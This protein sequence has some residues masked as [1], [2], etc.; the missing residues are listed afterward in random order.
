MNAD[1]TAYIGATG[2]VLSS[3]LFTYCE[4][5]VINYSDHSENATNSKDNISNTYTGSTK[6]G[7]SI[8]SKIYINNKC[9]NIYSSLIKNGVLKFYFDRNPN[10]RK[11]FDMGRTRIVAEALFKA[12]KS[13]NK[14]YKKQYLKG[15]TIG[16]INSEI[17]WHYRAYYLG[18][19]GSNANPADLGSTDKKNSGYDSNAWLF[20]PKIYWGDEKL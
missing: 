7:F 9:Y 16:G 13:I 18:I 1:D 6:K 8:T 19:L 10:Y 20:E 2:T 5:N 14:K 15:R 11:L 3:N 12:I 4:N 17:S